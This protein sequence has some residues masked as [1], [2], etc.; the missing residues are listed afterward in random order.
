MS[1]KQCVLPRGLVSLRKAASP[2][3]MAS[4]EAEETAPDPALHSAIPLRAL[5]LKTVQRRAYERGRS[6]AL[7]ETAETVTAAARTLS[8]SAQALAEA[9]SKDGPDLESFAVRLACV[10]A[11]EL[12]GKVV[13]AEDHDVRTIV[14]RVLG[15]VLPDLE[16]DAITLLGHPDDLAMLPGGLAGDEVETRADAT[17]QRGSFR[18]VGDDTELYAGL[19]ERLEEMKGRLLSE[20]L[21]DPS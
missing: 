6:V 3:S 11:G 17:L 7:A 1:P 12:V 5:D 9:R 19:S 21:H 20:G 2:P 8:L 16:V 4:G 14:R 15:E 13:D 10:V 18:V